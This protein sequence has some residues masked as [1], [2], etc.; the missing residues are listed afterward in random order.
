MLDH[1]RTPYFPANLE[2]LAPWVATHGLVAPYGKCQCG[3]GNDAPVSTYTRI[4]EGRAKG[5]PIPY[6][7]GHYAKY[8][9]RPAEERFWEKVDKRGHS[10]CWLWTASLDGKG[11]GQFWDG[12]RRRVA[13]NYSYELHN[14]TIP[15]GLIVCHDCP[16]GDNRRCVNPNHLFVG[17]QGDNMRDMVAKGRHYQPDVRG[18]KNGR[19]KHGR[20]VGL[21]RAS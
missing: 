6:I 14:G 5:E 17:T 20:Y 10:D 15:T 3:C 18:E 16:G 1:T 21:G 2:S 19:Y 7:R 12:K 8:I 13:H 4:K 9:S 11:Y